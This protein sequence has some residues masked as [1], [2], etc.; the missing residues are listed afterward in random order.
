MRVTLNT[1]AQERLL[2]IMALRQVQNPT[3]ML[4]VI[5][6]ETFQ[7]EIIQDQKQM[8]RERGNQQ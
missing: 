1:V 3:H 7:T 2:R 5:L 6:G 8:L 4:N